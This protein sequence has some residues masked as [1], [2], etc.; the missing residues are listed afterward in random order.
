MWHQSDGSHTNI[1]AN[2][3][4]GTSWGTAELIESDNAGNADLPQIAFDSSGNAL[5]V[6]S[7]SDSTRTNIMANHFN[8]TSW[9]TAEL[10]ETNNA[11]SAA[12]PQ[13]AIDSSGNALAVWHQRDGTRNNIWANRFN[14]TNWGTA[15]LIESDNAGHANGPQ[16]AF[17]SSGN[18]LAVWYQQDGTLNNNIWANRFNGTSWGT[19]ELIE[20]D[21]AGYAYSPQ[22]AFDSSGNALAV[23][24]QSDGAGYNIWA[25][26]FNGT[27]WGT[28][29]L[30]ETDNAG[31]AY[32]PQIAFDS[33][34]RALAV[35]RQS[36]GSRYNILAR[37]FE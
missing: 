25:N 15:E 31:F 26:R 4:N 10:I 9:G 27:S 12:Y 14:G 6:W 33:S 2:S 1:W 34:G 24:R 29:E 19:A 36:D 21:N 3:F 16:I 13:I 8:G 18:A 23:W 5:A 7:Q 11:G 30:I 28:A 20:S 35:W 17:D 37:R 22:I 32:G